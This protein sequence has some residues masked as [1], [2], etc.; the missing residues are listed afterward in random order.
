VFALVFAVAT[1]EQ[2]T[3]IYTY[4][5]AR[6]QFKEDMRFDKVVP[7]EVNPKSI[8]GL[9]TLH[10]HHFPPLGNLKGNT[11]SKSA[12]YKGLTTVNRRLL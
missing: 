6:E 12:T 10:P 3:R 11:V 2:T 7:L 8:V 4:M 1:P 5:N 9:P